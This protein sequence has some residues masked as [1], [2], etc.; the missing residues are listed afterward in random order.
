[1]INPGEPADRRP[2]SVSDVTALV[3]GTLARTP[4]LEDALI[5]G[6]VSNISRPVS[7]HLYFTLKD[8]GAAL[9]CVAFRTQAQRIPFRP[10]NGMTV[11]AHGR[12]D[13]YEQGG[14]YQLYVDR[15]EPSGIG[16]LHLAVEQ[17]RRKLAGEGLF[18][19]AHKR[20]LPLLPRRVVVVTSRTGAAWRDVCT[21][22]KRRAPGVDIILSPA[23]VQGEGAAE[24][25]VTALSRA[26]VAVRAD[27][28]LLVRGGGSLE[29]L[30]AFNDERVARAIRACPLPVVTGIGHE[31]DLTIADWA[32][33]H[34][35]A[36]PSAAAEVAVPA[37]AQLSV[38]LRSKTLRLVEALRRATTRHRR[39]L[40]R[41]MPRLERRSPQL[42]LAG[43]RQD[44][45]ARTARLR[46]ALLAEVALKR[47][48]LDA[49]AGRLALASPVQG[50]SARREVLDGRRR[51][52][53]QATA[54][55]LKDASRAL[56]GRRTH[57]GAVSPRRVLERG[58]SITTDS[59]S[60]VVIR[61]AD[62]LRS[63][64]RL[65][66]VLADGEADSR[67]V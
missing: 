37:V 30:M 9:K 21:V 42:R 19:A 28:V 45:D 59:D 52:L 18:E 12:I 63:G 54:A 50:M 53:A 38:D 24:V 48:R 64:Q 33:D 66:T 62:A 57:L 44:T 32:A 51:R 47:R 1:M 20:S 27:L 29:D 2:L 61:S 23:T 10:D 13:V 56:E 34:R 39:D 43:M 11:I 14:T 41:L 67:V 26:G 35:A 4:E 8:A 36:T 5:E 25:L 15:I 31:T 22:I 58:Y 17:T 46:S 49:V 7:G 55:L 60:G 40:D 6:E 3:K 16:A 65:R